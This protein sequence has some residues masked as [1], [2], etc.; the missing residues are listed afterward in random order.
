MLLA[1]IFPILHTISHLFLALTFCLF[2][3]RQK[4][5]HLVKGNFCFLGYI[6]QF[7]LKEPILNHVERT[8]ML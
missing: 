6:F 7:S 8:I 3:K 5:H 4:F 2:I 1:Y